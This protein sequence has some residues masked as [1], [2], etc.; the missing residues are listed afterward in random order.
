MYRAKLEK[1]GFIYIRVGVMSV[2]LLKDI[3]M[4]RIKSASNTTRVI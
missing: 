3:L 2:K 4:K 1:I